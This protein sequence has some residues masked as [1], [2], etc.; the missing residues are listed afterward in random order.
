MALTKIILRNFKSIGEEAQTIELAPYTLLFGPNSA[1]KSTLI[2]SLIYVHELLTK[3]TRDVH[4]TELGGEA[5]DLGGF[6]KTV[7]GQN[8]DRDIS[9][10]L[11]CL[12]DR[13]MIDGWID[14]GHMWRENVPWPHFCDSPELRPT[15]VI[16][17]AF[18]R[19][20]IGLA[21]NEDPKI[22]VKRFASG[23]NGVELAE[24][25]AKSAGKQVAL[26]CQS[27][28]E[29]YLNFDGVSMDLPSGVEWEYER[30]DWWT[31]DDPE[32]VELSQNDSEAHEMEVELLRPWSLDQSDALPKIDTSGACRLGIDYDDFESYFEE[33]EWFEG[34]GLNEL[35]LAEA[36]AVRPLEIVLNSLQRLLYIGPL[37]EIPSRARLGGG[38]KTDSAWWNGSRAWEFGSWHSFHRGSSELQM[39]Q[40]LGKDGLKT[41]YQV[42]TS[43]VSEI[44][45]DHFIWNLHAEDLDDGKFETAIA[46]L[47]ELPSRTRIFLEEESSKLELSAK[48][49]GAGISQIFPVVA[50]AAVE[51]HSL[52]AIEQP[53]LH[54][55]PALQTE[56]ADVFIDSN[57]SNH[58]K[59]LLETHSEHLVLRFLRRIEETHSSPESKY[60]ESNRLTGNFK[61]EDGR[62]LYIE[63]VPQREG[64]H[65]GVTNNDLVIYYVEPNKTG[66]VFHKIDISPDGDMTDWPNGF[67]T[68]REEELFG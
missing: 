61:D 48:D 57:F 49:V 50:A 21:S 30:T 55:H 44:P 16:R 27:V 4:K 38:D 20:D 54:V 35:R 6:L 14:P 42:R 17:S 46:A 62:E 67:F 9:I 13:E 53:E 7:H 64:K 32:A 5:I 1:G 58:N 8:P 34:T 65:P 11:E 39:N 29:L 25:E 66:S 28:R 37:R 52:I 26:I 40:W 3:G 19:L 68:E 23:L 12:H 41:G 36:V 10:E 22:I 59:F 2:Q 47:R 45:E 15:G 31:E 33:E 60:F 24:I 63:G 43:T 56:L 18:I 51:W